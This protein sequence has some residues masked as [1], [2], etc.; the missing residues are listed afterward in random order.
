MVWCSD[1]SGG[2][3]RNWVGKPRK[4]FDSTIRTK[5]CACVRDIMLDSPLLEEYDGC[6]PQSIECKILK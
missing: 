5:R 4:Y 2:I 3:A 6:D 1:Q